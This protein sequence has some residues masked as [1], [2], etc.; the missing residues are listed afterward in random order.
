MRC[1]EF[2]SSSPSPVTAT[3]HEGQGHHTVTAAALPPVGRLRLLGTRSFSAPKNISVRSW[4][5]ARFAGNTKIVAL[6]TSPPPCL[7]QRQK[8]TGQLQALRRGLYLP[9][10]RPS[11]L[12]LHERQHWGL[13]TSRAAMPPAGL[14]VWA[15]RTQRTQIGSPNLQ[16]RALPGK[17][18]QMWGNVS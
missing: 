14:Q 17:D 15:V 6:P 2:R 18:P 16:S 4:S 13:G 11:A 1:D 7:T 8:R 5:P 3:A 9:S 10:T 12:R